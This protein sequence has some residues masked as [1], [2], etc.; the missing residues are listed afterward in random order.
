MTSAVS[1][2][3]TCIACGT[4]PRQ[5]FRLS[6][7][8]WLRRCPRCGLGWWD[9]PPFDPA[10]F[11]DR[12]YFDGAE[13]SKGYDDYAALEPGVARTA[14][15]RLRRISRLHGPSRAAK[16][17]L[18]LGCGT[19]VF[20]DAARRAGWTVTGVEV[21]AYAAEQARQR[22]LAV[23]T[24]PV[25][26]L[27]PAEDAYD[28]VALWDVLE[29]LR[30]PA[31]VLC[32]AAKALRHG[33]VL[34]LS[35]GDVTSL[36]ARIAGPRWHLFN[37]PEHLFFFSPAALQ[38]L[39]TKAGCRVVRVTR[40]TNW[41]PVR[42]IAERLRKSTALPGAWGALLKSDISRWVIPATL[43]DVLGVYAVRR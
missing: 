23:E 10:A 18:E 26:G 7:G 28:C 1:A 42:Y 27:R 17:L 8:A 38:R 41:V 19:G 43:L 32:A 6:N 3:A 16:R 31:G 21:S 9:W 39:L 36:C 29:H 12:A 4:A 22:G 14:R 25:E 40:E 13:Q 30:D 20:L 37:L 5:S 11:Y 34:A 24:A 2:P 35:T 15:Q 33:G